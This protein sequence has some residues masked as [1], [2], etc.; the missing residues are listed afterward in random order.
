[1]FILITTYYKSQNTQR[2]NEINQCLINNIN[3]KH[4]KKI[5]LLNDDIYELDF[6]DDKSKVEQIIVDE[7]SKKRLKFSYA[8]NYIND[9]FKGEKCILANSDIY[10]DTS[11]ELLYNIN[12]NNLFIALSRYDNGRLFNKPLSQD[13][14]IF[15]SPLNI[16]LT[17]INYSFGILGCENRFAYVVNEHKYQVINPSFTIKSHHLHNSGFRTYNYRDRI[18]GLYLSVAPHTLGL[19]CKIGVYSRFK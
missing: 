3:N 9:N 18:R 10:Y 12:Y 15:E 6:L 8:V 17:K 2:Q 5:Y 11:L 4:I 1:M 19:R 16:D 7:D 13:S 14:W